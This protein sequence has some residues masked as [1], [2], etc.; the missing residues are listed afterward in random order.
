H[1]YPRLQRHVAEQ[2]RLILVR[3]PHRHLHQPISMISYGCYGDN[4]FFNILL[5]GLPDGLDDCGLK[6]KAMNRAEAQG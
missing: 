3:S 1:R 2:L 5:T 6:S 4:G